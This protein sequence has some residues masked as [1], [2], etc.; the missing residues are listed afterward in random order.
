[1]LVL[2][3]FGLRFGECAAVRVGAVDPLRRRLLVSASVS[4]LSGRLIWSTPKTH[5][6]R[7]VPVP[8]SLI[9]ALLARCCGRPSDALVFTS[10]QGGPLRIA[11]WRRR[12][13]DRAVAEVGQQG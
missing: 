8:R 5:Q 9:E 6:S 11:N 13:W 3:L 10:P 12:V 7:D 2:G 1:M 4:D